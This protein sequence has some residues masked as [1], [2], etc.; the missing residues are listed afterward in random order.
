MK[1]LTTFFFYKSDD[2][3]ITYWYCLAAFCVVAFIRTMF[4]EM[5]DIAAVHGV[6]LLLIWARFRKKKDKPRGTEKP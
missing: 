2:W 1:N 4:L 6:V 3:R 5:Y